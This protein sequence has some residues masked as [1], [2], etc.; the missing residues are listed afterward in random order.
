MRD[1]REMVAMLTVQWEVEEEAQVEG[2]VEVR[3]GTSVV[4]AGNRRIGDAGSRGEV[5]TSEPLA[6]RIQSRYQLLVHHLDLTFYIY[7]LTSYTLARPTN[8]LSSPFAT[9]VRI[10]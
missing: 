4:A 2:E 3:E 5:P 9:A 6:V 8:Q 1:A 10:A 7:N